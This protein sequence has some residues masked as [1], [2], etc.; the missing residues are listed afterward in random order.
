MTTA[1]APTSG[2][3][4]ARVG[5]QR[6]GTF[7]SGMIMPNI[8]ALIAWGYRL[9]PPLLRIGVGWTGI[10]SP[11]SSD[12]R[13][14]DDIGWQGAMT[15]SASYRGRFIISSAYTGR[16]SSTAPGGLVASIAVTGGSHGQLPSAAARRDARRRWAPS[17]DEHPDVPRRDDH[18]SARGAND[19]V[20]RQAVGR[21]DQG[22]LR[23]A[24]QHTSRPASWACPGVVGSPVSWPVMRAQRGPQ[25][26]GRLAG[27][28]E[29]AATVAI[30]VEPAKVLFL[31]N[32]INHGV[33]TPLGIE[34]SAENGY[35]ILFLLEANP[36]PGVG[37]LLAF[38][39]FGVGLATCLRARRDH[40]PVLRR[41]PRDLLPVRT[42]ASR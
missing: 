28:D 1:S 26:S 27:D 37:L 8:A 20:D 6:F 41:H 23:D 29:P 19:E 13:P 12:R 2:M 15:R 25:R 39:F 17:S 10:P 24:R 32:A 5:V 21:Q 11:T 7:L 18:G 40:H 38:T 36:G 3:Q 16:I 33:L 42:D 31:N 14:R 4:K 35:S 30:I 22:G 34:Q 9:H